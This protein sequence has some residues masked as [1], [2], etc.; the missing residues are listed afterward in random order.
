M[1]DQELR[2]CP[3][4]G[5]R[6]IEVAVGQYMHTYHINDLDDARRA[7]TYR[8]CVWWGDIYAPALPNRLFAPGADSRLAEALGGD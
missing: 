3:F 1:A 2:H 7:K 8:A 6:L 4:C 5:C